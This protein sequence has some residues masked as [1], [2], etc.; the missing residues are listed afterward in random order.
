MYACVQLGCAFVLVCDSRSCVFVDVSL[1]VG[2]Q[3]V[4]VYNSLCLGT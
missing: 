1:C 3:C 4:F 2:V